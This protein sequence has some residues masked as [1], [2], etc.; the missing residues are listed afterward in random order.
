[1]ARPMLPRT[2]VMPRRS[3]IGRPARLF[4]VA[5]ERGFLSP[6]LGFCQQNSGPIPGPLHVEVR[7][8]PNPDEKKHQVERWPFA[9]AT[10]L[11]IRAS[12]E[13]S[14]GRHRVLLVPG[15][16]AL[17]RN[18]ADIS[19]LLEPFRGRNHFLAHGRQGPVPQLALR[20]L[21]PDPCKKHVGDQFGKRVLRVNLFDEHLS[22]ITLRGARKA[23]HAQSFWNHEPWWVSYHVI[24]EYIT[25][26]SAAMQPPG[27]APSSTRTN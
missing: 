16:D 19:R 4:G 2:Y 17:T 7:Y 27:T 12:P 6:A 21:T 10:R 25:R 9:N 13:R 14:G 11:R 5:R 20:L 15:C 24:V 3:L 1:M 22:Y 26:L 23:D 18:W 8:P